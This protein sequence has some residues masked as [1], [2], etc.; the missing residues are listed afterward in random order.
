[1]LRFALLF[2]SVLAAFAAGH[3][4]EHSAVVYTTV[5]VMDGTTTT[6]VMT[7]AATDAAMSG[8]PMGS[9][10][11]AAS[12]ALARHTNVPAKMGAVGLVVAA[13]AGVG[14]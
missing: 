2:L 7:A 8:M 5:M 1:M 9:S 11:T 13:L 4:G 14:L 6:M 12:S 10:A 3:S